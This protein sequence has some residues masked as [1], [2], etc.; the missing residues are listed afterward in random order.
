M[1]KYTKQEHL[2]NLQR[3]IE[4]AKETGLKLNVPIISSKCCEECDKI[5]NT[6]ISFE[7]LL[8]NPIYLII[9]VKEAF[10]FAVTDLNQ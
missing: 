8:V 2:L 9:N 7:H 3:G 6:E 10:A 1:S 4:K 5:N